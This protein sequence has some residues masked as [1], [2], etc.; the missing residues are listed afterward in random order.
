MVVSRVVAAAWADGLGEDHPE[1]DHP[2]RD[3]PEE[4]HLEGGRPEGDRPKEDRLE[5][6][7]WALVAHERQREER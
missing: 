6:A 4:D 7:A 5:V 3:H 2:E 1:R